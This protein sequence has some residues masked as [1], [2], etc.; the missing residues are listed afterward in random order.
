MDTAKHLRHHS[1]VVE[2][3]GKPLVSVGKAFRWRKQREASA[4]H[5]ARQ[6]ERYQ[7]WKSD[8]NDPTLS[9]QGR[10]RMLAQVADA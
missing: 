10:A 1:R 9:A 3:G 4:R 7:A 8:P 5:I 2:R 6:A